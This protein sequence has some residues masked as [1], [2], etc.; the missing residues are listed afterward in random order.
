V[1]AAERDTSVSALVKHFLAELAGNESSAERLKHEERALRERISYFR[2]ADRQ[3]R[4]DVHGRANVT[5]PL[6]CSTPMTS[7]SRQVLQEFYVQATRA[8]RPD[9][10]AHDIAVG[11]VCTWLRF[12]VQEITLPVMIGALE[13]KENHGLSY[14][15][16]AIVA[17]ARALGCR[18][19]LSEDMRPRA[20]DRW[21]DHH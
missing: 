10:V 18:E 1:K 15:D 12:K 9:A 21:C 2:V 4:E 19:L 17:A 5:L 14:W 20:R 13:I 16:A 6:R 8:T 7:L 11:F 3:P